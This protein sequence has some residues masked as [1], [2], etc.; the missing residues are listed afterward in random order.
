MPPKK[1][2][3]DVKPFHP[4]P[5]VTSVLYVE[6][7]LEARD[8]LVSIITKRYPDVQLHTAE[9]GAMGLELFKKHLPNMVITDINMP[10]MDGISMARE[11]KALN[12]ETIVIALTAHSDTKFLLNAIEIGINHYVLKPLDYERLF[13]IVD[14]SL[15][16]IMLERRIRQQSDHIRKLSRAVDQSPCTVMI[17]DVNGIIEYVNPKF[18]ELTGYTAEE[19][20]GNT[21]RLLLSGSTPPDTYQQLWQTISSGREWHGEFLNRKRN[22]EKYWEAAS[23]S[24]VFNEDGAVTHY[25]AVKEDITARMQAEHEIVSLNINLA[26]RTQELETANSELEAFNST[27]SHDLRSPITTIHGFTQVLLEK[28]SGKIDEES[29]SYLAII[30]KEVRRMDAMIK[31]LLKFS[32]LSRQEMDKEEVDLSAIATTISLELRM[33]YP[34]RK[35][36]FTVAEGACCHGD[37]TLLRVVLENLIGNAWK[38]S[39]KKESAVIEFGMENHEGKPTF[40]VRD[41]GAGFDGSQADRLF[42]AF[43]R[44]HSDEDFEGFGIGLATVQRIIQR[45]GG[46]IHAIGEI[47]K[48]ATFYFTLGD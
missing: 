14:K 40:F 8:I 44:L 34:E 43:Q 29:M 13:A 25:V 26:A 47:D 19:A 4:D 30:H 45:H 7:E 9:N 15:A 22:G 18:T 1:S 11:V 28:C 27:V 24:P 12:P 48:G 20:L 39:S 46:H 17:T 36:A 10:L 23:I 41:N 16:T 31:A 5:G 42:G 32:R 38:Y 2:D 3:P 21:P 35:V 37:P 33:R 6:D